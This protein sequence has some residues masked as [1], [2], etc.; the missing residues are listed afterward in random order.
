MEY[1]MGTMTI[2][3]LEG[4]IT[5]AET[6]AIVNAANERLAGGGGVDGAIHR[7]AGIEQLHAA[8]KKL[9]GCK[10]GQA[11][12]TDGFKLKAKYI[13]HTVGPIYRGG[14]SG[15]ADLLKSAYK[16]SLALAEEYGCK[17]VAFPAIS[18]GVYGYPKE[19]AAQIAI[20]VVLDHAKKQGGIQQVVFVLF[21][22]EQ[23]ELYIQMIEK[24]I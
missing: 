20:G 8:C 21:G 3:I 15:E 6:D 4:D 10:T 13:I 11:K 17:S 16:S 7:A 22:A 23:Y 2:K 1:K 12:M 18:T 5:A 24:L 14:D 19:E 9:G